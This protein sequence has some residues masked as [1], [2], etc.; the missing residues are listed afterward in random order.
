MVFARR[1]CFKNQRPIEGHSRVVQLGSVSL[2]RLCRFRRA[3]RFSARSLVRSVW[4]GRSHLPCSA[5]SSEAASC[6]RQSPLAPIGRVDSAVL[7]FLTNQAAFRSDESESVFWTGAIGMERLVVSSFCPCRPTK[8]LMYISPPE[9]RSAAA[10]PMRAIWSSEAFVNNSMLKLAEMCRVVC[11]AAL[12]ASNVGSIRRSGDAT[13]TE[14]VSDRSL[15]SLQRSRT[16]QP[17]RASLPRAGLLVPVPVS[18]ADFSDNAGSVG[19]SRLGWD[20]PFCCIWH[21]V[22]SLRVSLRRHGQ[23]SGRYLIL[24]LKRRFP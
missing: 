10:Q 8:K 2:D 4:R 24:T 11:R 15:S 20:W 3:I 14:V 16:D 6:A 18:L 22:N 21:C 19:P 23:R 12:P 17:A 9:K 5:T 7:P 1:C 13:P